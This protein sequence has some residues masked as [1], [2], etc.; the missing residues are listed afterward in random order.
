MV[1]AGL[2]F[3]NIFSVELSVLRQLELRVGILP[4]FPLI[5]KTALHT[6]KKTFEKC[7]IF[8][9]VSINICTNIFYLIMETSCCKI[10]TLMLFVIGIKRDYN[11]YK[12]NGGP[13][14]CIQY[15]N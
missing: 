14:S 13:I 1:I 11:V 15:T 9:C 8:G 3:H 6:S 10:N 7:L 4:Y 12:L 2:T 5:R